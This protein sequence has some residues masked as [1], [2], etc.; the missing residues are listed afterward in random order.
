[1]QAIIFE[2]VETLSLVTVDDPSIVEAGDVIVEIDAAGICGSDLHPYLGRERGLDR[3]TIMGHEMV[4][5]VVEVGSDVRTF[6]RGDRVV[7]PFTTS[8]GA[9]PACESGLTSRCVRGQLFG[10]V[11]NGRGLHGAQAE[12][13]RVPLADTTLVAVPDELEDGLALLAGDVLSTALF[14]AELAG[15]R[16]GDTVAIVGCG[17]VGLLA[18]RAALARGA[19]E[20]FALD[21]VSSRLAIAERFGA[22]PVRIGDA[23]AIAF[24]RERT[25]GRGVDRAI[26]A[27]GSPQATRSAAELLRPGGSLAAVGVHTEPHLALSPGEIYDRNLTYAAG[28]CPA[29]RMLPAALELAERDARLLGELISHRLPLSAGVDAYR[30]LAAREEGWAKV[31]LVM[32]DAEPVLQNG[33]R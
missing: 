17:P 10:W 20:V 3:G 30:R 1:M 15:V 11:E 22:T 31:V 4:G 14:A 2:D 26:E 13:V 24:V 28:R 21:A 33:P 25:G 23:D 6:R 7:A 12:R 27:V 5:R 9:C 29:R 32:S 8:C 18:I 16:T 19:R